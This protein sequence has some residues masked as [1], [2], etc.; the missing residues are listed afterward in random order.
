MADFSHP[1]EFNHLRGL[2]DEGSGC[3]P[4]LLIHRAHIMAGRSGPVDPSPCRRFRII[5]IP[6]RQQHASITQPGLGHKMPWFAQL[7]HSRQEFSACRIEN[8]TSLLPPAINNLPEANCTASSG[9][10][11]RR[12]LIEAVAV[13]FQCEDRRFPRCSGS[14]SSRP[15]PCT[16]LAFPTPA[17]LLNDGRVLIVGG[18]ATA[19]HETRNCTNSEGW[20]FH[21]NCS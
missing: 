12:P 4:P 3:S 16:M 18:Y 1:A 19:F 11:K 9:S 20:H 8:S 6:A 13:N 21:G 2:R 17:T 15:F 7:P 14:R 5:R 10:L